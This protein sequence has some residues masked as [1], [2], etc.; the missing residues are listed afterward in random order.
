M[1]SSS[2]MSFS[3]R[4]QIDCVA[5][6]VHTRTHTHIDNYFGNMSG[7]YQ[8]IDPFFFNILQD[9]DDGWLLEITSAIRTADRPDFKSVWLMLRPNERPFGD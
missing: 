4:L 7:L 8:G 3:S 5:K 6:R 1:Y 2:V 9:H